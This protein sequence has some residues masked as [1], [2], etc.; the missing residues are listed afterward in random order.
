MQSS[1]DQRE[2]RCPCIVFWS[3][4]PWISIHVWLQLHLLNC[5]SCFLST[6]PLPQAWHRLPAKTSPLMIF[7]GLCADAMTAMK[8]APFPERS[9]N[10]V[11]HGLAATL[12]KAYCWN[13]DFNLSVLLRQSSAPAPC[14]ALA[15][16]GKR[17]GVIRYRRHLNQTPP[18]CPANIC[19]YCIWCFVPGIGQQMPD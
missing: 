13:T 14:P 4:C 16:M 10:S 17:G 5:W 2:G 6:N 9:R 3:L 19:K 12:H 8:N 15:V 7:L 18:F 11:I 1:E